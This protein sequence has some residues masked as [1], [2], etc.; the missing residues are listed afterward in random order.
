M[1]RKTKRIHVQDIISLYSTKDM[2]N[3]FHHGIDFSSIGCE[4]DMLMEHCSRDE[5]E[6]MD[7]SSDSFAL[8]FYLHFPFI[9]ELGDLVPF[10]SFEIKTLTTTNV[11]PP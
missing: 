8:Y 2:I 1:T 9:Y 4:R 11:T 6:N 5:R 3:K 7:I 10:S